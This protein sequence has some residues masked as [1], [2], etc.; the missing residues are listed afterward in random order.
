MKTQTAR[1]KLFISLAATGFLAVACGSSSSG[2]TPAAAPPPAAGSAVAATAPASAAAAK[3]VTVTTKTGPLGTY[4]VDGSG[5]TVYLWM[6]DTG[7]TSTCSGQCA[8]YWPPLTGAAKASGSVKQ[9][10]L[11]ASK[12]SDGSSQVTYSGHPLYYY[13]GDKSAGSTAGQGNSNFGAKWWV[14][15]VNGKALT[16]AASKTT[17]GYKY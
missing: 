8:T 4:L 15:G 14:V 7:S 5:R 2:S 13:A 9:A 10:D 17:G 11:A 12:R 3:A 1:A 16:G 6:A